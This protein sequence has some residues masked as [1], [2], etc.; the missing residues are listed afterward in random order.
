M[1]LVLEDLNSEDLSKESESLLDRLIITYSSHRDY[2]VLNSSDFY[3]VIPRGED[4][5][6]Y[7]LTYVYHLSLS[8]ILKAN[9]SYNDLV[10]VYGSG[11]ISLAS[12]QLYKRL[13]LQTFCITNTKERIDLA[14]GSGA[15]N[16]YTDFNNGK[17]IVGKSSDIA[18]VTSN[19]WN[20]W[21]LALKNA[22]PHSRISVLGFP[23]RN[24]KIQNNFNPLNPLY[25]YSKQLSIFFCGEL[26]N[27]EEDRKILRNTETQNMSCLVKDILSAKLNPQSLIS[28]TY[29]WKKL[30]DVYFRLEKR[31]PRDCTFILDWS[32]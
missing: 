9:Y 16:V 31:N 14:I 13:G 18:V 17:L 24:Q 26:V 19:S 29:S 8:A 25:T 3:Q 1:A 21:E 30:E 5:K 27:K 32:N 11:L 23:G 20:V 28:D 2:F 15:D 7:A 4:T 12:I 22:S 10:F 6:K